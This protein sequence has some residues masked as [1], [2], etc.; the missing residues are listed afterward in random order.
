MGSQDAE[1]WKRLIQGRPLDGLDL[2]TKDG[3]ID[4]SGL[5][6][7]DPT[8]LKTVRTPS[9]DV[10]QIGGLTEIKK[11]T[12]QSLDFSGSRL[13]GLRFHDC[14]LI[15]CVFDNCKCRD[16]RFW[17]TTFSDTSFRSADLRQS[18]MGGVQGKKVNVFRGV[19]FTEADLRQTAFLSA[20]FSACIFKNTRLDKVNFQGSRFTDCSFEGEMKEVCFYRHGFG[21]EAFPPNEMQNV[22][23]SRAQ[24]KSVEFRGLDLDKVRFP[25]DSKHIV[26]D[27]YPLALDRILNKLREQNDLASKTLAA[28]LGVYRKWVGQNQRR[29]VLNIDDVLE[30]GS[31]DGL[32]IILD[33]VG[34]RP[35]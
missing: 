3:R 11:A 30:A 25:A 23:F 14:K 13:P 7:P 27:D 16:W 9:A 8:I 22:D 1:V 26:L 17:G 2:G 21:A 12:W 33:E 29:G 15:D 18:A 32:R 20:E 28:Y 19:D 6:V 31:E 5:L 24:L 35:S 4:L 10:S 34:S